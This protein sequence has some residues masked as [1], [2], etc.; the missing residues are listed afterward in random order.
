MN[1]SILIIGGTGTTGRELVNI[2]NNNQ[3]EFKAL[4]RTNEKAE[5]FQSEGINTVVGEL[6]NW[7]SIT[8]ALSG[9][10]TIFL[11]TGAS[12]EN[13]KNQ[14][15]LIDRAK[16]AGVRKIVKVSAVVAETGSD[17]HLADWHGQIEDHLKD[18]G[19]E[20]VILRPHS[21][22][23]NML[24]S[25]P[26]IKG[27]GAFYESIGEGKLPMIDARDVATASYHCLLKDDFNN[28]TY[29]ITGPDS[30]GY[31]DVASSLSN[32]SGKSISF[33]NVPSEAHNQGMKAAG[34][35]EW[36]A[37][38]LTAMSKKWARSKDQPTNDF[39]NITGQTARSIDQFAQD[40]ADWFK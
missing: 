28:G 36:L 27:Q 6:G 29:V 17:V 19:L 15:G 38:D 39:Q 31:S 10:D 14:N 2:L 11:L 1:N 25:L 30:I 16:A 13:V 5:A 8:P 26:T 22:M 18:S 9:L 20:Y 37:D 33:L 7:D 40:Y 32:A 23:Q 12:P 21:F 35:P 34:L 24:M 4:A 3:V